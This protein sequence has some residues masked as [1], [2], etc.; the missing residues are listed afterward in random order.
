MF[1]QSIG[2]VPTFEVSGVFSPRLSR[3]SVCRRRWLDV[4]QLVWR[5][6]PS[7]RRAGLCQTAH[8][9]Q[10]AW[11]SQSSC[12]RHHTVDDTA[13]SRTGGLAA[14]QRT[15]GKPLISSD[16][17]QALSKIGHSG[18]GPC[19]SLL[20][21]HDLFWHSESIF[22]VTKKWVAFVS[23]ACFRYL[24]PLLSFICDSPGIARIRKRVFA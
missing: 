19:H 3:A 1:V 20:T 21:N 15:A 7:A 8:S 12:R 10:C 24:R 23:S 16:Q 22:A 5:A 2:G 6:R 4:R 13:R 11:R 17:S 9:S 18:Q 14:R